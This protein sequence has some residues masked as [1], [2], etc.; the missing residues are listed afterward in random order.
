MTP[1]APDLQS[2]VTFRDTRVMKSLLI[3]GV[4]LLALA[5]LFISIPVYERHTKIGWFMGAFG[6]VCVLWGHYGLVR[7]G[8]PLLTLS[9]KALTLSSLG[10]DV[11]IPWHQVRGID[12]VIFRTM[13]TLW[14]QL[15]PLIVPVKLRDVSVV[16]I[17]R[18]FYE[19][20]ILPAFPVLCHTPVFGRTFRPRGDNLIEV[21]LH[22]DLLPATSDEIR[23]DVAARWYAFREAD[24]KETDP[25][26]EIAAN[27][28][29][30]PSPGDQ[31]ATLSPD[32]AADTPA[33]QRVFDRIRFRINWEKK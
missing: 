2:I 21:C 30:K 25:K 32:A 27:R 33:R 1:Q 10:K 15:P 12:T 22:H 31:A 17:A 20:E 19:N 13:T 24:Q 5:A 4:M 6:I 28:G 26:N 8:K 3:V 7:G 11:V 14:S 18:D 16:L 29:L 23:K 9:P